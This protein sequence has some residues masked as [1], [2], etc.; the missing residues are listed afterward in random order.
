MNM[1]SPFGKFCRKLRLER[2][3][4]LLDMA[5]KLQVQSSYL[6]SVEVGRKS[7]PESWKDEIAN[8]YNLNIDE[9]KELEKAIDESIRQI[10]INMENRSD[11][12]RQFLLAFARKLDDLELSEKESIL[13]IL[14]NNKKN[15]GAS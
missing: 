11:K 13:K 5:K 15:G 9:K 10:K 3:E 8:L 12:D 4:L 7:V 14:Q 1:L 6:S 2:G